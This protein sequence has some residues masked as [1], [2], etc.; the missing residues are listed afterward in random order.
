MGSKDGILQDASAIF[1]GVD[2]HLSSWHV[3]VRSADVVMRRA[4]I[5]GGWDDL[6]KLLS[7]YQ[8]SRVTVVYEAGFSGFWLY[9]EVVA[10]GGICIVVPPSRI[11]VESGNRIK[12]DR[13]DSAKL[14]QL[15][16]I[17]QLPSVWV[18]S[19]KQR[20]DREVFRERRRMVRQCR[21][22][23]SQ[24][25][26]F[27]HLYGINVPCKRGR[28]PKVYED[29][30]WQIRFDNEFTQESFQ[31]LLER[32]RFLSQQVKAQTKLAER[33]A[34]TPDYREKVSWLTSLHGIAKFTAIELLVVLG[35]IE[36]FRRAEQLS[37]YA[38]LTPGEYS[39]GSTV[40]RGH[41]SRSGRAVLRGRLVEASWIAIR[42]DAELAEVYRRICV[43]SGKKRAIVGV[44]R[45]L[46]LRVRRLYL[47]GRCYELSAAN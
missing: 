26:A 20:Q 1:V 44:A 17:G 34:D 38:G 10:W 36:R 30:L 16:S 11:P 15:A 25:K 43:R 2:V 9:D 6:R 4:S 18:P 40:R 5:T 23:Q 45:R 8:A 19:L 31:G 3:T 21:Q 12:T 41:I 7:V 39:S 35:D 28:W 32:Y 14:A 42:Y 13:R 22:V 33:L 29:R 27:L 24:I 46:L 47:D 37:A